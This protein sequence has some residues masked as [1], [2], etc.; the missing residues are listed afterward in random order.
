[1]NE[2]KEKIIVDYPIFVSNYNISITKPRVS[3]K[4]QTALSSSGIRLGKNSF[5]FNGGVKI[6]Y[7]G[8]HPL[9]PAT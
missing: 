4:L 7:R 8:V 5:C 9:S 2:K 6:K 1:M 3:D